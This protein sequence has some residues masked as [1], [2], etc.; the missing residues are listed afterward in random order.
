[1]RIAKQRVMIAVLTVFGIVV[2]GLLSPSHAA[3]CTHK[4]GS[5]LSLTGAYGAHG[6]PISR[7]A[8]LGVEQVN[9]VS[10]FQ[11][12]HWQHCLSCGHF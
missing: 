11:S 9:E 5:I 4:I 10:C 8:Q 2:A 12:L 3:Q 1:M 6:V 7:A